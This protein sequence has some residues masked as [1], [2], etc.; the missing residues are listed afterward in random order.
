MTENKNETKKN[1]WVS[2]VEYF[3]TLSIF[4]IGYGILINYMLHIVI[5]VPL[6]WY[7]VPAWG[8]VMFFVKVEFT[9]WYYNLKRR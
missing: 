2:I 4:M 1:E 7:T 6:E 8:L 9:E 3:K 5:H